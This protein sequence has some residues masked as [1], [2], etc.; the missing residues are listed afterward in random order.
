MNRDSEKYGIVL[1]AQVMRAQ[2]LE[3]RERSREFSKT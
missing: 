3:E 2:E 1:I